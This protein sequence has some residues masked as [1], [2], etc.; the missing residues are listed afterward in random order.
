MTG[1][2]LIALI[3][4]QPIAFACG[5]IALA[6]GVTLYFRFDA[7]NEAQTGYEAKEKEARRFEQNVRHLAGLA[8]A[9]RQVQDAGRQFESRLVRAGQL[10]S[11]LQIFYRLENE[12]GVRLLDVRQQSIPAPR[13]NQPRG[14]Y[15]PV[16]FTVSI[17]GTFQEVFDFLRR[18]ETGS[19]FVR[20]NQVTFNKAEAN[21][22]GRGSASASLMTVTFGLELLGTP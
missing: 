5:L 21:A 9:T 11:N 14:A 6:A 18:V 12:T 8:E 15:V 13:P 10:A 2:D 20:F 1:A 17:Q 16:P 3:K 19:H 22:S 7:I 4:K